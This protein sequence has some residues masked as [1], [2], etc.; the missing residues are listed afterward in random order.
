MDIAPIIKMKPTTGF[1]VFSFILSTLPFGILILY[2]QERKLFLET[3]VIRLVLLA[4]SITIPIYIAFA[5][6]FGAFFVFTLRM[7]PTDKTH[8]DPS[9]KIMI[10]CSFASIVTSMIYLTV[11][12]TFLKNGSI[13]LYLKENVIIVSAIL[14]FAI[15]IVGFSCVILL[16]RLLMNFKFFTKPF[17]KSNNN[18]S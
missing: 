4:F 10:C 2:F 3:D 13:Q 1:V 14:L 11:A 15:M 18:S 7:D 5:I 16:L 9:A 12:A 6:A 17:N 8:E